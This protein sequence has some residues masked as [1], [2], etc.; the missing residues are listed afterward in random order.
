MSTDVKTTNASLQVWDNDIIFSQIIT[1]LH[2][3]MNSLY[4]LCLLCK[5]GW[6]YAIPA[7]WKRPLL[8]HI[9]KFRL[10]VETAGHKLPIQLG[11]HIYYGG[12]LH[13]L[14]LTMLSAR[15]DLVNYDNLSRL[16]QFTHKLVSLDINLCSNIRSSEFERM[17]CSNPDM[18]KS[19]IIFHL[20]ETKFSVPAMKKVLQMMPNLEVL[21]L[22]FTMADDELL[23]TIAE[24]NC[25]LC[26]LALESCV[27]ITNMGIEEIVDACPELDYLNLVE[28]HDFNDE[29]YVES[30]GILL[31]WD[32]SRYGDDE[33]DIS[34]SL[35]DDTDFYGTELSDIYLDD[36]GGGAGSP[37]LMFFR[38]NSEDD[39]DS[40][41][42]DSDYNEDDAVL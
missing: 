22:S 29:D 27:D 5:R 20:S 23:F 18:C 33:S 34:G 41:D 7:L 26:N 40:G 3:D 24:S 1:Y 31:D 16:F 8:K 25:K 21:D 4:T 39:S 11:D 14:D 12:L 15:W 2:N 30:R 28:C 42:D 37:A 32:G 9:N 17:F 19:L 6:C 13:T 38:H 35:D 36:R 10:L